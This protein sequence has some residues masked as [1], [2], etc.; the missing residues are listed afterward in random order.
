MVAA[1]EH[2]AGAEAL[3]KR[4]ATRSPIAVQ[5]HKAMIDSA[6]DSSLE[7]AL[8]YE[9]ESVVAAHMTKDTHEGTAAF[10]D[11]REPEFLGE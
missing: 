10:F 9:I 6:Q 11:K 4:I 2:R 5:L 7:A 1:G 3:A 8:Q